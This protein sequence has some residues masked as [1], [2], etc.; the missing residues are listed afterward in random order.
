MSGLRLQCAFVFKPDR[1]IGRR[2]KLGVTSA[3]APLTTK[4]RTSREVA[5][6]PFVAR[7]AVEGIQIEQPAKCDVLRRSCIGRAQL[8]QRQVRERAIGLSSR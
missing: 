5:N 1:V 4:S 3:L 8:W 6:V 2:R 7:A